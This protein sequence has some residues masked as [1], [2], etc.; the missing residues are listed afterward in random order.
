MAKACRPPPG[1]SEVASLLAPHPPTQYDSGQAVDD[2]PTQQRSWGR[3]LRPQR[4]RG[5][6]ARPHPRAAEGIKKERCTQHNAARRA[7]SPSTT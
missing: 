1:H 5:I 2:Q 3:R 7:H 6:A 4:S